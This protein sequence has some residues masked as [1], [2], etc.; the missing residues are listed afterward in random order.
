MSGHYAS[1]GRDGIHDLL[2][3]ET[4][5]ATADT[6][7]ALNEDLAAGGAVSGPAARAWTAALPPAPT[8]RAQTVMPASWPARPNSWKSKPP[9]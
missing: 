7:T 6:L 2:D 4:A 1:R 9:G 5:R 3:I 8:S